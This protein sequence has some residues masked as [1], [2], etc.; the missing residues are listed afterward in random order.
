[1]NN[2]GGAGGSTLI[3]LQTPDGTEE[4]P[5]FGS[6]AKQQQKQVQMEEDINLNVIRDR[7]Q[8]IRKIESDIVEVNQ[9]FKDLAGI[10]HEQGTVIDSIEGNIEN[11]S[12]QI[13]H[14]TQELYKASEYSRKAR[15]KKFCLILVLL[16]VL[17]A[18]FLIIYFSK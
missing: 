18:I 8:A 12:V 2:K 7:E 4:P 3:D 6:T 15:Q 14:G 11:S 10:V 1:M 5:S 17:G 13:Q 16:A 9:I